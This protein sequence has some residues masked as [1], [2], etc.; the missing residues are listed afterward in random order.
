MLERLADLALHLGDRA[1]GR[2]LDHLVGANAVAQHVE[3]IAGEQAA[4]ERHE[5]RRVER[6]ADLFAGGLLEAGLL[7]EE[8]D[9]EAIEAGVAQGFAVLGDVHA[10]AARAA[11]SRGQ[12]DVLS[13]ISWADIPSSSRRRESSLTRL[14]TVK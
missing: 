2:A 5:E 1:I 14:P 6:E 12:E 7:L 9:A 3:H 8:H 13:M 4:G 10:E 11:C